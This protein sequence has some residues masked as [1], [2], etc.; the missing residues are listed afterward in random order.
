MKT[1]IKGVFLFGAV[2]IVGSTVVMGLRG[3]EYSVDRVPVKCTVDDVLVYEGTSACIEV[4]STGSTTRV[5]IHGGLFCMF[6]KEYYISN[7]V[8]MTTKELAK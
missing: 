1:F 2:F 5:D 3:L 8:K 4:K 6:P 7:N